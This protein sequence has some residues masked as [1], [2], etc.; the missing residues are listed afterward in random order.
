MADAVFGTE[1]LFATNTTRV[2]AFAN[3]TISVA[4]EVPLI[5]KKFWPNTMVC[6]TADIA[7]IAGVSALAVVEAI[8]NV[9][10]AILWG[11]VVVEDMVISAV[12]EPDVEVDS[13]A[14]SYNRTSRADPPILIHGPSVRTA[15]SQVV[16]CKRPT[17][18]STRASLAVIVASWVITH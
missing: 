5:A 16:N 6:G 14:D 9:F 11:L 13:K 15:R 3:R 7:R 1:R 12:A 8:A 17:V 18:I 4:V 2:T 10:C